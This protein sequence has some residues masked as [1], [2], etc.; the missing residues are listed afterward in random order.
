MKADLAEVQ[1]LRVRRLGGALVATAMK[2][3]AL[4]PLDEEGAAVAVTDT[5]RPL[6]VLHGAPVVALRATLAGSGTTPPRNQPERELLDER[7]V[8]IHGPSPSE[9]EKKSSSHRMA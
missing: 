3:P 9:A 6:G 5:S 4:I 2:G 1:R 8:N 7:L